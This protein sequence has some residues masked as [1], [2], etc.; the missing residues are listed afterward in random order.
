[1]AEVPWNG[2]KWEYKVVE[3]SGSFSTPEKLEAY[4][5]ELG[6]DGW[7]FCVGTERRG[8]FKRPLVEV[9]FLV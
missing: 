3:P 4:L 1:M 2:Q 8:I 9:D 7:Q 5:N 6:E